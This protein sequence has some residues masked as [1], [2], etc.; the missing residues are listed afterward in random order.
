[1]A[2]MIARPRDDGGAAGFVSYDATF[3]SRGKLMA[4]FDLRGKT[5][6]VTGGYSIQA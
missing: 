1:M 5:A 6:L 2:M 4:P 3:L